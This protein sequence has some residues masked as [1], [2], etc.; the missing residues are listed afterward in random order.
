MTGDDRRGCNRL[1]IE[2][3]S[4]QTK[5]N[6]LEI[7]GKQNNRPSQVL[8]GGPRPEWANLYGRRGPKT[9]EMRD[10]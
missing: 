7:T 3:L 10:T 2:W 1:G 4:R 6:E 8:S 5:Q 9:E